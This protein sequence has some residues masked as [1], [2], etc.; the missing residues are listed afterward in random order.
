MRIGTRG[1]Q[2]A[3]TQ[4]KMVK[5]ML[6]KAH[7]QLQVEIDIIVTSGD[8]NQK[9]PMVGDGRSLK[10]DFV[11]EI[12][13]ALLEG[14]IDLAVHS[15]K[16]M[17]L[18]S[19]EG[20]LVGATPA[21]E[22]SR[23]AILFNKKHQGVEDIL[24]LP[25]GSVIGTSSLRRGHSLLQLREDFKIKPIRGNVETRIRKMT[26]EDFDA[27]VLAAAGLKRLGMASVVDQY[28]MPEQMMPAPAQGILG[29]QCREG[30]QPVRDLL[31]AIHDS[32]VGLIARAERHFGQLFDGG[33]HTPMGCVAVI[34]DDAMEL[35]GMYIHKDQMYKGQ[36]TGIKLQPEE[37]A[38][39]VADQIWRQING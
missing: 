9:V 31:S 21:R 28:M 4:T 1:S 3:L 20:L 36:A 37:L 39:T 18:K 35:S 19:P 22:D 33:C 12:E 34:R 14:D 27:I 29:L 11:K 25:I 32:E 13:R 5:A 2:L 30:D 10:I 38:A 15:M 24:E 8:R 16:D 7:P 6:E 23:D 26:D 17:P